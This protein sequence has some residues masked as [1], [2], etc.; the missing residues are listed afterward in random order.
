MKT[1]FF[2]TSFVFKVWHSV[3]CSIETIAGM[4]VLMYNPQL[5]HYSVRK[6]SLHFARIT[7][8]PSFCEDSYRTHELDLWVAPLQIIYCSLFFQLTEPKFRAL[9]TSR[10]T[11]RTFNEQLCP[12]ALTSQWR[13]MNE[14]VRKCARSSR[15][16]RKKFSRETTKP[17]FL[18]IALPSWTP[19]AQ[20]LT[21]EK[22]CSKWFS[23]NII[24]K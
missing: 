8:S 24:L 17:C 22:A 16:V 12:I 5:Q 2:L 15:Y 7:T 11:Y 20:I 23:L 4:S 19:A 6:W 18:D 10:K 21:K 1:S 13:D 14:L 9:L 3:S